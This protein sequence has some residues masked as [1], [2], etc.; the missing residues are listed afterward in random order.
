[1]PGAVSKSRARAAPAALQREDKRVEVL[2]SR[3]LMSS[4]PPH[5]S[6]VAG[7]WMTTAL[8]SSGE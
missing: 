4:F 7:G 3:V 1:M 5:H 2:Q 6:I 8:I